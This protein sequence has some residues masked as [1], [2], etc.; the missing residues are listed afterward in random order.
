[1]VPAGLS[2]ALLFDF[3]KEERGRQLAGEGD[4]GDGVARPAVRSNDDTGSGG[5]GIGVV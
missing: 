4:L 1:M 2:R 5:W 3:K